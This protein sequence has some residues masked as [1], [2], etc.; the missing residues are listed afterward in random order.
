MQD[1]AAALPARLLGAQPASAS[2]ISAPRPAARPRS[3]R[4]PGAE[5]LAV[6]RSAKRLKR[7]EENLR[8]LGLAPRPASPTPLTLDERPFDAILLDAPCSATGTIRRHPDVAWTKGPRRTWP[9]SPISRAASSTRRPAASPGG[10]LVYCTCSLEP[11]EGERQAEA[12]LARHADFERPG[13]SPEEV[14]GLSGPRHPV[15]RP[16]HPADPPSPRSGRGGLDGFFAARF[17]RRT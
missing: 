9:S 5:V 17:L 3:S 16:A 4:P 11:E 7:L 1:A 2:R 14:G 8:R 10:R 13:R 15:R 6:D 12:F